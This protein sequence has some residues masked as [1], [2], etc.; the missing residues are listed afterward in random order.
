MNQVTH[1]LDGSSFYGSNAR[2]ASILRR[3][4]GGQMKTK[5]HSSYR[6]GILPTCGSKLLKNEDVP[7]CKD[8]ENFITGEEK[9]QI[10]R[11]RHLD[12]SRVQSFELIYYA[13]L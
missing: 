6:E 1:W 10:R 11:N 12:T 5:K 9:K 8:A 13:K 4:K 2:L 3:R 7:S